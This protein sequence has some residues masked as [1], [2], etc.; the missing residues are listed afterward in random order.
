ME[1]VL[2]V[3]TFAPWKMDVH[4]EKSNALMDPVPR[5]ALTLYP[6]RQQTL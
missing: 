3:T 5:I 1:V 2:L 4:L 6:P